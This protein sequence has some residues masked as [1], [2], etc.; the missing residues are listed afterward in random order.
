MKTVGDLLGLGRGLIGCGGIRPTPIAR[1]DLDLGM[2]SKPGDERFGGAVGQQIDGIAFLQ[3]TQD[4]P[5]ALS[6]AQGPIVDPQYA[7][8]GNFGNVGEMMGDSSAI[9][10]L[11]PITGL[12]GDF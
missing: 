3:I 7:H 9:A 10:Q 11:D 2:L 8:G 6:F 1:D 5:I 4:R 12:Y